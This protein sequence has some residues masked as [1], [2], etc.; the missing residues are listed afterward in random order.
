M[1]KH[2]HN[3]ATAE[4]AVIAKLTKMGYICSVP[5]VHEARYD[6]ILDM[7]N[8]VKRV[9][10]KCGFFSKGKLRVNLRGDINGRKVP[11]GEKEIDAFIVYNPR[12]DEAYW[13][14]VEDS[15]KYGM[16]RDVDSYR[17]HDIRLKL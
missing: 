6:I 17:P 3:G 9:Q 12:D 13:F 16:K 11:Y 5:V 8:E 4:A 1:D 7:E 14:D 2:A 15:P 10:I